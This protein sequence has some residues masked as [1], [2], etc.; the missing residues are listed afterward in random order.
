VKSADIVVIG[1]GVIGLSVA[2]HLARRKAGSVVVLERGQ[3]LGNGSTGKCAGGIRQQ[4]A[5]APNVIVS[6]ESVK[7]L[8]HFEELTGVP[9]D[10]FQNGYLFVLDSQAQLEHFRANVELQRS[11]GVDSR[12]ITPDE[13]REIVPQLNLEGLVGATF[14]PTDGLASPHEMTQGFARAAKNHG[15][16]ILTEVEAVG[17]TIE[18][19][20]V[21]GV[22]TSQ[23]AIETRAVVNAAGPY[24]RSV[25]AWAGVDLPVE[26]VR[27]HIFTTRPLEFLTV[28]FPMVVDMGSGVYM[29]SESGGMLMGLA[30][31]DEPFGFNEDVDWEFMP[32]VVEPA[33][34]RIPALE[35]AE[36]LTGWAG[37]YEDT[38]DHMAVLGPVP[39]VEGLFLA[40]GFSGHGL[41]HAPEA[42]RLVA[43]CV[44][45]EPLPAELSTLGFERFT[46]GEIH[47]EVNVI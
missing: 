15:A 25:A 24:A 30:D 6:R 7:F 39:G 43:A 4:F 5:T 35:E 34:H 29:H 16:E 21:R 11:L 40:N 38:P 47:A 44:A 8:E 45:G 22:V 3:F 18:G 28:H 32:R 41:M 37:L 1:G 23:G 12:L 27:R 26:P 9:C 33:M 2:F 17:L 36:I 31:K 46:R 19:G 20:R 42:G 10:F 14:C 13:A